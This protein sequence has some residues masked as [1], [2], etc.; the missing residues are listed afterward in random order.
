MRKMKKHIMA[1]ITV[2][3]VDSVAKKI[4]TT[5]RCEEACIK[6]PS[7]DIKNHLVGRNISGED[8]TIHLAMPEEESAPIVKAYFTMWD[9]V[10]TRFITKKKDLKMKTPII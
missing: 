4:G 8:N 1:L 2:E 7:E 10:Q 6:D 5:G 9:N 3:E